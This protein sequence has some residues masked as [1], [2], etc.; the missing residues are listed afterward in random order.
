MIKG[1]VYTLSELEQQVVELVGKARHKNKVS[2]NWDGHR[3]VNKV[4][5]SDLNVAGFGGEYIFCRENN[6]MPDF[7]IGN[8]SKVIGTDNY[9]CWWNYHSVDVKV[10]RN[11]DNPLMVPTYAKTHC[12]I[13]ALFSCKYPKY[14]FEGYATNSMLFKIENVKQTIVPAYVV[15]KSEL[16]SHLEILN[17]IDNG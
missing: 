17:K 15:D 2:T 6:V 4:S 13:F 5:S 14:R 7:I 16:L 10:N 12:D 11:P 3:T 1:K 9:D 8:T